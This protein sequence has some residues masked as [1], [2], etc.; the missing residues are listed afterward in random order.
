MGQTMVPGAAAWWGESRVR[1]AVGTGSNRASPRMPRP[2]G[3]GFM[4]MPFHNE[5]VGRA[6]CPPEVVHAADHATATRDCAMPERGPQAKNA[7]RS[8]AESACSLRHGL[9]AWA[10]E[11]GEAVA[12]A[13]VRS[14]D[15][16][17]PGAG[18]EGSGGAMGRINVNRRNLKSPWNPHPVSVCASFRRNQPD[19]GVK[20]RADCGYLGVHGLIGAKSQC[21][22]ANP[23]GQGRAPL[24]PSGPSPGSPTGVKTVS[25]LMLAPR[26]RHSSKL[27]TT[28]IPS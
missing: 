10:G 1:A 25:R 20:K 26:A 19:T 3:S 2:I 15:P 4:R 16:N 12:G 7:T 6:L 27:E 21:R 17:R 9:G 13:Q 22:G 5:A 24:L 8:Y 11:R 23:E 14:E 28:R 18:S